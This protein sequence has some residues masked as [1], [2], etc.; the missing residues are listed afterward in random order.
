MSISLSAGRS[1]YAS[2]L[3]AI[4][5]YW[6]P[7]VRSMFFL[8]F[9][10]GLPY[11]LVFGTLSRRLREAGIERATIGF[12]SL[13]MLAYAFKWL[14]SPVVD[15]VP[16][17][18]FTKKMGRR[19]SWMLL[20]QIAIMASLVGMALSD[21][22]QN[23][24]ALVIFALLAAFSSA[25]QD[26]SIDAYRIEA[27]KEELQASMAA[28]YMIGYR[29]AMIVSFS[30]A[31]YIAAFFDVSDSSYM[32]FSWMIA[33]IAM[34]GMMLVGIITTLLISEPE[35]LKDPGT[36]KREGHI[37]E[38]IEQ[39]AQIPAFIRRSLDWIYNAIISPFLDFFIRY[40]WHALLI[41]LLIGTYRISDIVLGVMSNVF[42]VDMG[43]SKTEVATIANIYGTIMTLLGASL[44]G[45]LIVRYGVMKVLF[46]GAVLSSATNILFSMMSVMSK[47]LVL[48]SLVISADNLSAGIATVAFIA[49]LSSLTNISYTAT[50]YALFSS[51]MLLLPKLIGGFSG[52]I[53]D[54][55]SY[56]KFFI[57]T[58]L[59]G[60]PV[61]IF[62]IL[63]AKYIPSSGYRTHAK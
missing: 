29:I 3:E 6:R 57:F 30:G 51:I 62:I 1:A 26:I 2:W 53:V 22:Q 25:T 31:F 11:M 49:Y 60:V 42:Y 33:Y 48:L 28:I 8:G 39:Y 34:A 19:R 47:S 54:K 10:A 37:K 24:S 45:I 7:K 50:Q 46:L 32:H 17:P 21:P 40:R 23:L 12:I 14:W 58:A 59:I 63:A 18:F 9:S 16:I 20:A 36:L 41:L 15:R 56:G 27:V 43:F 61:L 5:T 13:V 52:V 44:G 38:Q 4:K 35:V 55:I